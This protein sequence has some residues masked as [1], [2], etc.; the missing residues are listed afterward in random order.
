MTPGLF[1][2]LLRILWAFC[3][4]RRALPSDDLTAIFT[5]VSAVPAVAAPV[6]IVLV[7]MAV[8]LFLPLAVAAIA[9]AAVAIAVAAGVVVAAATAP[10]G[11]V[12]QPV[13]VH[14]REDLQ[15]EV[16]LCRQQPPQPG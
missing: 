9:A 16:E 8:E 11:L 15:A 6:A 5:K 7:S 10:P 4:F 3:L 2:S 12:V 13:V 1:I 14:R